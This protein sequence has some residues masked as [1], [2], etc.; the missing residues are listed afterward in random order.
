MKELIINKNN[1]QDLIDKKYIKYN[2]YYKRLKI[3]ININILTIDLPDLLVLDCSWNNL[4]KL[5]INNLINLQI[6]NCFNNQLTELNINNLINLQELTCS[7]NKLKELNIN[8]LINLQYL[9]CYD[10]QL[11]KLN[12]NNLINLQILFCTNNQLNYINYNNYILFIDNNY[13]YNIINTEYLTNNLI[14]QEEYNKINNVI[15][16]LFN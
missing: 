15:D 10:N 5:N 6:L 7:K 8:N 13:I 4:Q 9:S 11:T 16:D 14:S 12:I 1:L 2:D 3:L